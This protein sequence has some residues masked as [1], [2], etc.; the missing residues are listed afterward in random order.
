MGNQVKFKERFTID[1]DERCV[2]LNATALSA[3]AALTADEVMKIPFDD[4][5]GL[6]FKSPGF[7]SGSAV[8]FIINGKKLVN[9]S[10]LPVCVCAAYEDKT[11]ELQPII[12]ELNK[13]LGVGI[14]D[15]KKALKYPE[16]KYDGRYQLVD[17]VEAREKAEKAEIIKRCNVCGQI[18]CYNQADVKKNI[19]N[20]KSAVLS[21]I[22]Q[23]AGGISGAYTASAVNHANAQNSLNK[24]VDF[25]RCP[26][27][28][29]TNLSVISEEEFEKIKEQNQAVQQPTTV[30][31]AD[32]LK[33]FKELLDMGA[34]TREEFDAKK[35]ELLGL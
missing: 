7:M 10:G 14:I 20:A 5:S 9:K 18:F 30:S 22:G 31:V 34:I 16:E 33:K 1:Y 11:N 28:N 25:N 21:G 15:Y 3:N 35:K 17:L 32:E 19:D 29:S 4:I 23:I 27:C 13:V 12:N 2:L 6:G 24:I 26:Q 8:M